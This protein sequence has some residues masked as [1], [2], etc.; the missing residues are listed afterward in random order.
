MN[1][2]V[3]VVEDDP[4][5]RKLF[6]DILSMKG[7]EVLEAINGREAVD[8]A[9]SETPALILL[10][11]QMPVMSGIE[12]LALLKADDKTASITV[13]ALTS[14]AM[15]GDEQKFRQAGCDAYI[16]KP[17]DV[18]NFLER[19]EQYFGGKEGA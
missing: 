17:I 18:P 3:L 13:W 10:D 9:R 14:Y 15:P 2:T 4:K 12:A 5:N 6:R 11:I 16:T 7:Y 1:R 8:L 19:I